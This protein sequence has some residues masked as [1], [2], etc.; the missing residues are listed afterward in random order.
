V[1]Q[2]LNA[3]RAQR[4]GRCPLGY[5]VRLVRLRVPARAQLQPTATDPARYSYAL[6]T[7]SGA[8]AFPVF[9]ACAAPPLLR[10]TF[11]NNIHQLTLL[12]LNMASRGGPSMRFPRG[13]GAAGGRIQR[14]KTHVIPFTDHSGREALM[15]F[16]GWVS[17]PPVC[18]MEGTPWP[19]SLLPPSLASM[20]LRRS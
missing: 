18:A 5:Q 19:P 16:D 14:V 20:E 1:H 13:G 11:L 8:L 10:Y 4:R 15:V 2:T 9:C 3:R 12:H 7:H 17:C 6:T